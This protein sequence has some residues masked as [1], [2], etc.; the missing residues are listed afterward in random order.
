MIPIFYEINSINKKSYPVDSDDIGGIGEI[1]LLKFI[2]VCTS[3]LGVI[4][5]S[6]TE[7]IG[8]VGRTDWC[9]CC[10]RMSLD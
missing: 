8:M 9:C 1:L 5:E 7:A 6:F 2:I 10:C 4:D 3:S